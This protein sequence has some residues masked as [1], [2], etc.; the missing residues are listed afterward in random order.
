MKRAIR[1]LD[2]AQLTRWL[3]WAALA[4]IVW[5]WLW[6]SSLDQPRQQHKP[7]ACYPTATG[8]TCDY[9]EEGWQP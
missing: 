3:G 8:S 9:L 2:W 6:L 4:L 5:C 7:T 1:W